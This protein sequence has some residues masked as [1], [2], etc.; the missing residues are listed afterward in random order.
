MS[1]DTKKQV[2]FSLDHFGEKSVVLG[3]TGSGKSYGT[4]VLIE[5]GLEQGVR[6]VIIDPQ[7]AYENLAG[8][9]YINA[10][11]IRDP[12][13]LGRLIAMTNRNIVIR[14]K[15]LS[16]IEQNKFLKDFFTTYKKYQQKGIKCV[17]IDEAHK[18]IPQY[19]RSTAKETILGLI[20]ENRSDGLGVI[21]VS[22]MP[23]RVDK[24]AIKQASNKFVGFM[25]EMND[26]KAVKGFLVG[27]EDESIF[28][29][30]KTGEFYT[31]ISGG[32]AAGVMK[33][34]KAKT[35]HSGDSPKNLL[36]ENT[37]VFNEHLKTL[38][39]F[40]LR[41]ESHMAD[42]IVS[43]TLPSKATT[44]HLVGLGVKISLGMGVAALASNLVGRVVPNFKLGPISSRSIVGAG[45]TIVL[46]LGHRLAAS[47]NFDKVAD[48]LK[49]AAAGS[50]AF[51]LGSIVVDVMA[52][53][54]ISNR[55]LGTAVQMSTGVAPAQEEANA[56]DLNTAFD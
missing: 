11:E 53:T 8:M 47:K 13:A 14:M 40:K 42:G 39:K 46:Y 1:I 50:A 20:Q 54:G 48:V 6:F 36:S 56:P 35:Q 43:E 21:I 3:I 18:F 27:K 44:M 2:D 22:Q 34:R 19:E 52:A 10:E 5:E 26:I 25:D 31:K 15:K 41:G 37:P 30:L 9:E 28:R 51:T 17:V 49:Y 33:F 12:S 4:R 32:D 23:A 55:L 38:K 24:A 7:L 16:I 45:T 29:K